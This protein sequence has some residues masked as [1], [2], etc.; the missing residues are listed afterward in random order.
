M[1]SSSTGSSFRS[2][3]S[4]AHGTGEEGVHSSPVAYRVRPL[5]YE[6]LV[7]C[8]CKRKA[9]RWISWSSDN[10]GRRYYTCMRR[11]DGGCT[12]WEW[13]DGVT[14]CEWLKE[15]LIDMRDKI[16]ALRRENLHLT[17]S[18]AD[19]RA[20]LDQMLFQGRQVEQALRLKLA[21]KDAE[22]AA[23]GERLRRFDKERVVLRITILTCI[24]VCVGM[25]IR[26]L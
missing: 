9:P 23:L 3:A 22:L 19:T 17:D 20:E 12:F 6:P 5:E 2:S 1:A 25:L 26:T 16:W 8:H 15:L 14:R 21:E 11:R 7:Y 13:H 18:I 4:A 10:P 24:C